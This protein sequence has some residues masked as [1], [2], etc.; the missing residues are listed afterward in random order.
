MGKPFNCLAG[1]LDDS[2]VPFGF[3]LV[4]A[5]LNGDG[6]EDV[7]LQRN[8]SVVVYRSRG[9]GSFETP[10]GLPR[11]ATWRISPCWT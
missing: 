10:L 11:A 8:G 1:V 3:K 2:S 9:D 5:D 4:A 7:A 6:L